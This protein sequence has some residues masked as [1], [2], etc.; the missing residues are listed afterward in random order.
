MLI[1][2]VEVEGIEKQANKQKSRVKQQRPPLCPHIVCLHISVMYISRDVR[3][4]RTD[5]I[6]PHYCTTSHLLHK[7]A[8]IYLV[9]VKLFG[10]LCSSCFVLGRILL[11][12][13]TKQILDFQGK[14]IQVLDRSEIHSFSLYYRNIS[15]LCAKSPSTVIFQKRSIQKRC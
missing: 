7:K 12:A 8:L 9:K 5:L 6:C 3:E 15:L 11:W 4:R 2:A 13:I 1:H 14:S 10:Y